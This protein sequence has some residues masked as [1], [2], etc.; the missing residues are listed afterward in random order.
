M[1]D[2]DAALLQPDVDA[3]WLLPDVD[4]M[5]L[6]SVTVLVQRVIPCLHGRNDISRLWDISLRS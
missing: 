4:A 6:P 2:V 5:W 1:L 3:A